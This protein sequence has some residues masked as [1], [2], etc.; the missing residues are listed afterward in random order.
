MMALTEY[1][2]ILMQGMVFQ[3]NVGV[4][5]EEKK[6]GQPFTVDVIFFCRKLA[7][8]DNDRLDQTIDYGVAFHVVRQIV[9]NARCD[10]IERLAGMIAELL[11]NRFLLADAVEITVRKP[12]APIDGQFEAMGIRIFRERS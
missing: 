11:L 7:A 9:E 3:G 6:A 1:D 12:Q 8:C 10:L 2:R 4:L 5:A